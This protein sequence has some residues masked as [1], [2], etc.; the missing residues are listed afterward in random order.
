M[1]WGDVERR[2]SS[3]CVMFCSPRLSILSASVLSVA[4]LLKSS[5][6]FRFSPC[7]PGLRDMTWWWASP[8]TQNFANPVVTLQCWGSVK[9]SCSTGES[10][11]L[12]D[13]RLEK[14]G[15]FTLVHVLA[16]QSKHQDRCEEAPPLN[17]KQGHSEARRDRGGQTPLSARRHTETNV[18]SV[19]AAKNGQPF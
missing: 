10:Q 1:T 11:G 17:M 15:C 13:T 8:C 16:S 19:Q 14:R 12:A 3:S 5:I 2:P 4:F 7:R 6:T 18:N 9:T